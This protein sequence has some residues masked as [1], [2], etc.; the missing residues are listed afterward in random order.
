MRKIAKQVHRS[1]TTYRAMPELWFNLA[2]GSNLAIPFGMWTG[3]HTMLIVACLL[4]VLI[5]VWYG[6][7]YRT[8]RKPARRSVAA[9]ARSRRANSRKAA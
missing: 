1:A 8:A 6:L 2:F 9:T 4:N 5:V 7:G 3:N